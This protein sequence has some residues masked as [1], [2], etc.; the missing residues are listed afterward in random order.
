M[1]ETWIEIVDTVVK[2][3]LGALI[4]GVFSYLTLLKT[5]KHEFDLLDKQRRKE[6]TFEKKD[7]YLSYLSEA[8]ALVQTYITSSCYC[9]TPEYKSFLKTY[10]RLQIT[11]PDPI[12]AV[13]HRLLCAVNEFIV[14]NKEGLERDLRKGMR[15]KIDESLGELQLLA[16]LDLE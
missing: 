6:D 7:V 3:G 9:D 13:A 16:K 1:A 14:I 10:N 8:Q 11:A 4:S 5:K 12:R 2:V 15:Q